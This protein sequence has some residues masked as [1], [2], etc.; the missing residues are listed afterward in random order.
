MGYWIVTIWAIT[1]SVAISYAAPA[2]AAAL[3]RV[4]GSQ[5]QEGITVS[6]ACGFVVQICGL[7]LAGQM[8]VIGTETVLI[9]QSVFLLIGCL[10]VRKLRG[11]EPMS[12]G[13]PVLSPW[14]GLREGL[15][16]IGKD[17]LIRWMMVLNLISMMFNYGAFN[18]VL[19]FILKDVY[20]GNAA[21]F[22]WMLVLF[23]SGA[24]T[25]NFIMLRYMPLMRP[26]RLF[27][28]M[29]LT[30]MVIFIIYWFGPHLWV[31]VA[32][33]FLWG[34]NMGITSTTSRAIVQESAQEQFRARILSVYNAG[35]IGSQPFGALLLGL[36]IDAVGPLN[37]M[38][39]GMLVS[40]G[41]FLA[42]TAVSPVWRYRSQIEP[43]SKEYGAY[44]PQ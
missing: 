10:M 7:A 23:Y 18:I 42:G 6:T 41:I 37:G 26:G 40:A 8:E 25:S 34:L 13:G 28:G 1:M 35:A 21:F 3:N 11:L 19:P 16:N 33:T 15:V 9:T 31:M 27:L 30:R 36:V 32:A 29:Q 38:I 39:P 17:R 14:A 43:A 5:V 22:G 20:G 4:A 44:K 12:Q 2:H 24:A